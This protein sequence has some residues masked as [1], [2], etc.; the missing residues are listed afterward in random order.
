MHVLKNVHDCSFFNGGILFSSIVLITVAMISLYAF[1]LLV[2]T[3]LVVP[4]SF[5]D[6][7]G[8]LYG[9]YMRFAILSSIAL[10]QVSVLFYRLEKTDSI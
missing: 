10:S 4:G 2:K 7:G 3:R 5:G 8:Q 9:Q 1:L 6:I